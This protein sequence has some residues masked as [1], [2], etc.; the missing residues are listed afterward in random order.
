MPEGDTLARI[1][2]VLRPI[3]AGKRIVSARGRPGG[4]RLELV[5][6]ATVDN[7]EARGKHLLIGFDNGLTLHTH[8]GMNGS[9]H[10]YRAGERWRRPASGAVAVLTTPDSTAV[11]FD[12]PTVEL[13]ETRALAAHPV[14]RALGSDIATG[15]FDLDAAL[16]TL[17]EPRRAAM[18]VGDALIDQTALAGLGNVYRS[19][20][21]FIERVNP[22]TPVSE[23]SD[24]QLRA[25]LERGAALVRANSAGGA[26]V[27]TTAGLPNSV[28]VYGH[29][30]RPCP[31]CATRIVSKATRARPESSPRRA[32][33][34][35]SCQ[36]LPRSAPGPAGL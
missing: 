1:A 21:P 15:E 31:R 2:Q 23:V 12:A 5:V 8:L 28:Y 24:K 9:W 27:T 30:G 11:C 29:T 20:L 35:P 17:R 26:R 4:A 19:E 18:A 6:G 32:Y 34:C 3:L 25:M 36:P 10:R 14:L 33:W 22:L 7:V 16:G 13:I